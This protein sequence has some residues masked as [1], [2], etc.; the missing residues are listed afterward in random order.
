MAVVCSPEPNNFVHTP[1]KEADNWHPRVEIEW[2]NTYMVYALTTCG[3]KSGLLPAIM[4]ALKSNDVPSGGNFRSV[5][6]SNNDIPN[7]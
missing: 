1:P 4:S 6:I 5:I 2:C 7:E 3:R